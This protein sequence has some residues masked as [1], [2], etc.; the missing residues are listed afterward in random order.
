MNIID[1]FP[2]EFKISNPQ[3]FPHCVISVMDNFLWDIPLHSDLSSLL[4]NLY[5]K[6]GSLFF[7]EDVL[8]WRCGILFIS[9]A[10]GLPR[11]F[12][13]LLVAQMDWQDSLGCGTFLS[14]E[15][16]SLSFPSSLD[17]LVLMH[18]YNPDSFLPQIL[19]ADGTIQSHSPFTVQYYPY[20]RVGMFSFP[21]NLLHH[22]SHLYSWTFLSKRQFLFVC[23]SQVNISVTTSRYFVFYCK[24]K[25]HGICS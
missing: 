21:F 1:R 11:D 19:Q 23:Y 18:V 25:K 6:M 16:S 10:F 24:F 2:E 13:C 22:F 4:P 20:F 5:L 17:E 3:R 7:L 12:V 9:R 14:W 15:N 8:L